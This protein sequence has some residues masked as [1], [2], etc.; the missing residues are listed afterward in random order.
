V[1]S[2]S[3]QVRVVHLPPAALD[4]LA[5]GDLDA[6]S[7]A[8]PVPLSPICLDP[9]WRQIWAIRSEQVART[10]DDAAWV[11]GVVVDGRSGVVVGQAG[12]HG[13]PDAR[14]MVEVGYEIDPALRRRGY[15][16][17]ALE[18]LVRRAAAEPGVAVVRASI[19]PENVASNALTQSFGFAQVGE[20][21]D[22]EDGL[23]ILF[24]LDPRAW[25]EEAAW[26][27]RLAAAWASLD[28]IADDDPTG[29]EAF[30]A[31]IDAIVAERTVPDGVA[32]FER[33]CA[34]D[35]TGHSDRAVP[36]YRE[37][38]AAGLTGL[39]RRRAVIQL[40]SS[41]RNLHRSDEALALLLAEQDNGSDGLDDAVAAFLA[42]A[43]VDVGQEREAVRVALTALAPHLPRYQRSVARYAQALVEPA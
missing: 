9:G 5:D 33:A 25:V 35:S 19:S 7:A 1:P 11:T 41:L 32:A 28:D 14:G 4:A 3:Q 34:F 24:E 22:E 36:L 37:A 29:E 12:F 38:L 17:A 18:A 40:A 16:R 13:P 2:P 23:E 42:L 20:Q 21:W 43:L 10:P 31:R 39:R 8:S 6:A 15:A 27:A 30:R 26:G